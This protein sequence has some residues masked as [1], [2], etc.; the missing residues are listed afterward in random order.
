MVSFLQKNAPD[1]LLQK[2]NLKGEVKEIAKLQKKQMLAGALKAYNKLRVDAANAQEDAEDDDST[3]STGTLPLSLLLV[4]LLLPPPPPPPLLLLL[5]LLLLRMMLLM[6]RLAGSDDDVSLAAD[7]A[8]AAA[9]PAA[10]AADEAPAMQ[11]MG[12]KKATETSPLVAKDGD[13]DEKKSGG[14]CGC[15]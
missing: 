5:L 9:A 13:A 2:Y 14:F 4:L 3:G 6:L 8:P 12:G 1:E 7:S 15:C 11:S 10:A